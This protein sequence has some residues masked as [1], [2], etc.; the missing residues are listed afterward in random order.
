MR[1]GI[2]RLRIVDFDDVCVTN[3]NRQLHA[4]KGNIGK[5]RCELMAERL[6][7]INPMADI[8]AVKM[9]YQGSAPRNSGRQTRLCRRCHRSIHGEM[10]SHC[11]LPD[12]GRPPCVKYG[13]CRSMGPYAN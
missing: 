3:V 2:G 4:M 5:P 7:L 8:E 6:R 11:D 12:T 10:S 13:G 1:S 9:F